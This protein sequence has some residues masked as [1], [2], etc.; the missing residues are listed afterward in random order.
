MTSKQYTATIN[1][2]TQVCSRDRGGLTKDQIMK[3]LK[4]NTIQKQS[5]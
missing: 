4:K 1:N 3:E 2:K 5:K